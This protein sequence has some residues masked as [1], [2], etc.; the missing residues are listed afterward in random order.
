ME[1]TDQDDEGQHVKYNAELRWFTICNV[2]A[3]SSSLAFLMAILAYF[4][5]N[6]GGPSSVGLGTIVWQKRGPCRGKGDLSRMSS[7]L[8]YG[9]K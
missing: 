3:C 1:H 8:T 4:T 2:L 5:S 7:K 9:Q 6:N